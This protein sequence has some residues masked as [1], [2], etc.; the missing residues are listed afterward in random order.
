MTKQ[1]E[2]F[3]SYKKK[4]NKVDLELPFHILT[5]IDFIAKHKSSNRNSIL[6]DAINIYLST[7]NIENIFKRYGLKIKLK[8][9]TSYDFE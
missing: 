4:I 8:H 9:G 7:S 2:L 6:L 5:E 1:S 3:S